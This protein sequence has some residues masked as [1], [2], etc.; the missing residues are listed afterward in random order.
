MIFIVTDRKI[1]RC[2]NIFNNKKSTDT[3]YLQNKFL[4]GTNACF[5]H[6]PYLEIGIVKRKSLLDFTR[7]SLPANNHILSKHWLLKNHYFNHVPIPP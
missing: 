3:D 2:H 6:N 4:R 5:P 7:G 1:L